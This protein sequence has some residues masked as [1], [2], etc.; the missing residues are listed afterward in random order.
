MDEVFCFFT[1]GALSH[2]CSQKKFL[3]FFEKKNQRT[4]ITLDLR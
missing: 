4:F 2:D 1:S 3:I